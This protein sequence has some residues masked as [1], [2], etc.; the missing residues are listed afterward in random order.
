MPKDRILALDLD[1]TIVDSESAYDHALRS[2]GIDPVGETFLEARK[3]TKEKLSP[4]S[5]SARSRFLYFKVLLEISGNYSSKK[6]IELFQSYQKALA[7]HIFDQCVVLGRQKLLEEMRSKFKQIIII[8][9]ETT[10]TQ[11]QKIEAIDP[12]GRFF[13]QIITS[14]EVGVEK[15]DLHIFNYALKKLNCTPE[16]VTFIGD[17]FTNDIQPAIHLGMNAIKTIE[18]R[19]DK[20]IS[21]NHHIINKL[22]EYSLFL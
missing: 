15:P 17:S 10:F 16:Q 22:D 6:H 12:D 3:I 13:D 2:I 1:D 18:F 20:L 4:E 8:T 21:K 14:E 11:I 5:P 7:K 19:D 9:N